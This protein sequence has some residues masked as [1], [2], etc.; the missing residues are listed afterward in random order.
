MSDRPPR[1]LFVDLDAYRRT[2]RIVLSQQPPARR[3]S[4]VRRLA[5]WLLGF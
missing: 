1:A 2:R 4:W 3:P 5:F